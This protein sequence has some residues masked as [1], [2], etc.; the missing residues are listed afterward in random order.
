[1]FGTKKVKLSALGQLQ[2][3]FD[4]LENGS[5]NISKTEALK[6]IE[7]AI[8]TLEDHQQDIE[9]L[10]TLIRVPTDSKPEKSRGPGSPW[11]GQVL[12]A[13]DVQWWFGFPAG[14]QVAIDCGKGIGPVL[15]NTDHL[16]NLARSH[17]VL[18]GMLKAA[19]PKL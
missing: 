9:H 7:L 15:I 3:Y 13:K 16:H 14:I 1:M 6:A 10:Q 11:P 17:E 19:H 8:I 18:R 4:T 2:S 5:G 12:P